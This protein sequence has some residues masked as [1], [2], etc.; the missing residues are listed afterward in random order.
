[1]ILE[2]LRCTLRIQVQALCSVRSKGARVNPSSVQRSYK[3]RLLASLPA[4][5]IKQLSRHLVPVPLPSGLVLRE[6]GLTMENAVFIEDGVCSIV[7]SME[8]GTTIEAGVVGREGFVG[9]D[10]VLGVARSP[11]RTLMQVA[12]YG[13]RVKTTILKELADAFAPLRLSLL[14]SVHL[15]LVQTAQT[16]ACNRV[17][18]LNERLARWLLMCQDRVESDEILI[19]QELLAGMLGT[20]RS[21][22]T[23]AAGILQ[24]A[25]LITYARGKVTIQNRAS[26]MDASCEC[27]HIVHDEAVRLGLFEH[28]LPD[29]GQD[30]ASAGL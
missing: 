4:S 14:R 21:S 16:A 5:V 7:V 24:Q 30:R 2:T 12:G 6:P 23:V 15:L 1:M 17:H 11:N 26:L 20:H 27:Y 3:N 19:T 13:Y 22:V 25:G 29:C 9:V 8:D 10:E 28:S 18:E